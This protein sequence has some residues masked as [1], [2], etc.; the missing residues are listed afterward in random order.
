MISRSGGTRTTWSPRR[1]RSRMHVGARI[2]DGRRREDEAI[3]RRTLECADRAA[4]PEVVEAHVTALGVNAAFGTAVARR[5]H[6]RSQ[7]RF[8]AIVET[9]VGTEAAAYWQ[10]YVV[11]L[12]RTLTMRRSGCE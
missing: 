7:C 3:G 12:G 5:R 2:V 8:V 11:A 6:V 4:D 9:G 1:W 10:R